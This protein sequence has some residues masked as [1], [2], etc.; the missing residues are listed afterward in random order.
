MALAWGL[1]W[2]TAWAAEPVAVPTPSTY[3]PSRSLAPLIHAVEPAVVSV[4]VQAA[5]EA[6]P[7]AW[8]A[9]TGEGSGFVIAPDG[10]VLTNFHVV[11]GASAI[12]LEWSDGTSRPA[13]MVGGDASL[14]VALLRVETSDPLPFVTLGDSDQ[15]EVG[16]WVVAMGNGLGLGTTATAGIVSGKRRSLGR[17]PFGTGPSLDARSPGFIQTDAA[18]NQGSSGGPLFDLDGR[19]VGMSTAIITNANTV[20]F[21][22]PSNLVTAI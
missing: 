12:S 9:E 1:T 20:G 2:G 10:L 3:D 13:R 14:D 18:I 4:V 21:A 5:G 16:D 8:L 22:I 15:L 7:H 17:D 6:S 11:D 19:V